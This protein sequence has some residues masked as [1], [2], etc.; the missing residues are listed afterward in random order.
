M[1]IL[2]TQDERCWSLAFLPGTPEGKLE[3]STCCHQTPLSSQEGDGHSWGDMSGL[4]PSL[5]I[6]TL[7]PS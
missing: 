1:E 5:V 6:S 2:N 7:A 4:E 3:A